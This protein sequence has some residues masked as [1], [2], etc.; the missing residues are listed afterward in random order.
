MC[1]L[2][3]ASRIAVLDGELCMTSRALVAAVGPW[4]QLVVVNGSDHANR[5]MSHRLR[6]V[7]NDVRLVRTRYGVFADEQHSQY[8]AVDLDLCGIWIGCIAGGLFPPEDVRRT[9]A[10]VLRRDR[11]TLLSLTLS[12]RGTSADTRPCIPTCVKMIAKREGFDV[13]LVDQTIYQ[14]GKMHWFLFECRSK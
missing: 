10:S 9:F 5:S 2:H 12:L 6:R 14:G 7:A 8:D 11:A 13:R 3:R 1:A 4:L